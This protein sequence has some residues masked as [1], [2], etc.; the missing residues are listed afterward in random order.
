[1]TI[2]PMEITLLINS[3]RSLQSFFIRTGATPAAVSWWWPPTRVEPGAR[4]AAGKMGSFRGK[5]CE[6]VGKTHGKVE[7]MWEK[8]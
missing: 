6:N 2:N 8:P 4:A 5:S 1:M 7:K 3:F